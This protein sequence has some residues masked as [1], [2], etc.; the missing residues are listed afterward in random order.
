MVRAISG[1][2]YKI[3]IF[4][5]NFVRNNTFLINKMFYVHQNKYILDSVDYYVNAVK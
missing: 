1:R 5:P 4:D 3:K 2:V